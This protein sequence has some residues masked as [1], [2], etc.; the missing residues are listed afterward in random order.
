MTQATLS[1]KINKTTGEM[2][3]LIQKSKRK[4]LELDVLTSFAE[5]KQG[6]VKN[7]K[8]VNILWKKLK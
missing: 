3:E 2:Q 5:V 6:K 7:F 4:L 8:T 1:K